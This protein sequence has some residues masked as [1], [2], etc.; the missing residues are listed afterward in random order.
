MTDK[1][2]PNLLALFQARPPLRYLPPADFAPEER[3]TTGIDGVA[4]FVS[5][6]QEKKEAEKDL[7]YTESHLERRDREKLEK[8]QHQKWLLT[9]G[10]KEQYK[11]AED[12]NIQGDPFKTL[13]VSRLPYT[14]TPRDLENEFNR[15]GPI[16]KVRLPKDSQGK[17]RGYGFVLFENERDMKAAYKEIESFIMKGRRAIVDVE[18]GRTVKDWRPRRFG[19]GIGGRHYTKVPVAKPFGFG[20]PPAGPGGFGRG[21]FRGGFGDRGGSFR[22]RGG[23][24]FRGGGGYGG[25][26]GIGYN[27]PPDGAPMGPRQGGGYGGRFDDRGG[28][29]NA[30]HEPLPPRG[31]G[32]R[33]RD[34][35]FSSGSKRPYEDSG[36]DRPQ[37]RRRY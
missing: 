7:P 31:G 14:A 21:G 11:P 30:N 18:R 33:D 1:L 37:Q 2:P 29:R 13:F 4:N 16:E 9:E 20:G 22:G 27:G 32:Y 34:R 12:P 23:G 8:Q 19:G 10:V 3:R 5:A 15:F 36:Y 26:G 28:P 24:G 17:P 6:L 25:R 35:D